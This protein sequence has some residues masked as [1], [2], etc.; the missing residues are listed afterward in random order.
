MKEIVRIL[1]INFLPDDENICYY[2]CPDIINGD[3]KYLIQI[4]FIC[5]KEVPET[6]NDYIYY[7]L[8]SNE[9]TIK[10][11]FSPEEAIKECFKM[12]YPFLDG[13]KCV[14]S[15]NNYKVLPSKNK[16]GICF[17][18]IDACK[19]EGYLFYNNI[20]ECYENCD[21]YTFKDDSG[22]D[23]VVNNEN[24]VKE[25]PEG[26]RK[27]DGNICKS[28]RFYKLNDNNEK[29][30]VDYCT[31]EVNGIPYFSYY[32]SDN[33]C[34]DLCIN[35]DQSEKFALEAIDN[36]QQCIS[37]CPTDTDVNY[38]Y[39]E[40][41]KI[42]LKKCDKYYLNK[43][44][45]ETICVNI[46]PDGN[47]IFPGNICS[48]DEYCPKEAPFFITL[49]SEDENGNQIINKKCI[50]NCFDQDEPYNF[51]LLS[52]KE[53]LKNVPE[54]Y[55][56]ENYFLYHKGLYTS[57]CPINNF[58]EEYSECIKSTNCEHYITKKYIEI[59]GEEEISSICQETCDTEVN[60]ITSLDECLS[61]CP[62]GE[63]FIKEGNICSSKCSDNDF[64]EFFKNSVNGD[65]I[66]YKCVS[67]CSLTNNRHY[68]KYGEK[69]CISDC[70]DLYEYNNICYLDC[71]EA[72]E[73]K[74]YSSY[75]E[76]KK[77]CQS[78][79]CN[80]EY[81]YYDEDEKICANDCSML[82]KII[83]EDT[84]HCVNSCDKFIEIKNNKL[85]CVSICTDQKKRYSLSDKICKPK[86]EKYVRKGTNE[87]INT[88]D[89]K[90]IKE[91]DEY[92]C[93]DNNDNCPETHPFY[94]ND[95]PNLCLL[96]C[97]QGDY[98]DSINGGTNSHLCINSCSS[99][100]YIYNYDA[101][102]QGNTYKGDA[103]VWIALKPINHILE[104]MVIVILNVIQ[105]LW[106]IILIM[107]I[108]IF[109]GLIVMKLA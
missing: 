100:L 73:G 60:Y 11:Y 78:E 22:N 44:S 109:V 107:M 70:G 24:C 8:S 9:I 14:N 6:F 16:L 106:E 58:G 1:I 69:E 88:C 48:N 82:S 95:N 89:K 102:L 103:C 76:G 64:Y 75:N 96:S 21:Y 83:D 80:G 74:I 77:K 108:I 51:F 81:P 31:K 45:G 23:I 46:C 34:L 97:N 105:I 29:I 84:F 86:C 90:Y 39:Y 33:K 55:T 10:K 35:N 26:Y 19:S 54:D 57:N 71:K 53:C 87:C 50:I 72:P 99:P 42:C 40:N 91:N 52:T 15:C 85:H 47:F 4:D 25:C 68:Y 3:D 61:E 20:K 13:N 66:I 98:I 65:Y 2:N 56:V 67:S 36:H 63:N 32:N 94:Y 28:Q 18:D 93:Y 79:V 37:N 41:Q 62:I 30:Y 12:G 27:S 92:I 101:T 59:I 43:S 104:Q 7:E 49:L 17:E 5:Y 38:Y